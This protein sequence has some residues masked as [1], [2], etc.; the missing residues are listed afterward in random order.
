MK[1]GLLLVE[2]VFESLWK[3]GGGRGELNSKI[4]G[5]YH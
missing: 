3:V 1:R 4:I 2:D 5:F